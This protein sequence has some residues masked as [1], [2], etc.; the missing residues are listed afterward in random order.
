MKK[1]IRQYAP[2]GQMTSGGAGNNPGAMGNDVSVSQKT[3][4]TS[5]DSNSADVSGPNRD[6]D[7]DDSGVSRRKEN[8][9]SLT[10]T[11]KDQTGSGENMATES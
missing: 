3:D 2:D 6:S 9:G 5:T 4:D 7:E 11:D 8:N 10:G 1:Q